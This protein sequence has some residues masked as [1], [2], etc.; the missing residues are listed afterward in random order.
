MIDRNLAPVLR[1][2]VVIYGGES[3]QLRSDVTVLP[4]S[5]VQELE[6]I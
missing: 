5:R 2:A 6:W 4:W 3:Q 1:E